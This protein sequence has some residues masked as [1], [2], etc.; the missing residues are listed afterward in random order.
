MTLFSDQKHWKYSVVQEDN[1][2]KWTE[3]VGAFLPIGP[4]SADSLPQLQA[5]EST[6][7]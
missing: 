4:Q 3:E 5:P 2:Q 6:Y 7:A 1:L